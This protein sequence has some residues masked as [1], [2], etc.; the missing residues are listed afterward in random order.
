MPT[1]DQRC[2]YGQACL[3][4]QAILPFLPETLPESLPILLPEVFAGARRA[5][6]TAPEGTSCR[7]VRLRGLESGEPACL[8]VG[9]HAVVY[10]TYCRSLLPESLAQRL[11]A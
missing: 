5:V 2:C 9:G 7:K 1:G 6:K 8:L 10:G 3:R 4:V 11:N